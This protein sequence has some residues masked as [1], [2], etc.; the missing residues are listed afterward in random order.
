MKKFLIY[1]MIAICS[2]TALGEDF[3]V[4]LD[5]RP[6]NLLF[7]EQIAR[8]GNPTERLQ[9][10]PRSMLGRLYR[11]GQ[12]DQVISWVKERIQP[13]DILFVSADMWLYGGLVASR[14]AAIDE[15]TVLTRLR[16]LEEIGGNGVRVHA[17]ATIPRLSLRTSDLQAPHETTLSKWAARGDLP[18]ARAMLAARV[19][20]EPVP[21]PEGVPAEVVDEYLEVRVRNVSTIIE[22]VEMTRIGFIDSLVLGQDDS[23]KTGLHH[24][25]QD[26]IREAIRKS[27]VSDKATVISGIDELTMSMVSGVWAKRAGISPRVKVVYSEPEAATQIPPLESLPLETMIRQHL[28]LSGAQLVKDG[29]EVELYVYVPYEQPWRVPGEERRPESESFVDTVRQAMLDSPGLAVADLSLVNRMDPFLAEKA[30]KELD[31]F[32]LEGFASWNTPANTVGTVISQL[33]CHQIA[34][35]SPHWSLYDRLESEKTHQAFL[36]AR[37][38]D[39]YLYQTVV[40]D[41]IRKDVTKGLSSTA[42]PLLNLFGPAGVVIRGRLIQWAHQL[43]EERYLGRTFL[44]EPQNLEVQFDRSKLEVVLPWPR[45]FEIEARL[46]LRISPTESKL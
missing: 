18:S 16:A 6:A 43:F 4:P 7:V 44:L 35:R 11:P 21:Y 29:A 27:N 1:L 8:I 33:V 9:A 39:D 32:E 10:P 34:E 36:L 17:L 2:A 38:I 37:F 46:D 12:S 22:L 26:E 13:G 20:G 14:T 15:P 41:D 19:D 31:L 45:D 23:N 28:E 30:L 5:D 3:L 42:D 40:R 24:F 25:E